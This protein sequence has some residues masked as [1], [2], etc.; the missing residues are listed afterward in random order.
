MSYP[1]SRR[2]AVEIWAVRDFRLPAGFRSRIRLNGIRHFAASF[3][4]VD[5]LDEGFGAGRAYLTLIKGR[6]RKV[7]LISS[8]ICAKKQTR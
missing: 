5:A 7:A 4:P 8:R 2:S 3:F 1:R 6:L